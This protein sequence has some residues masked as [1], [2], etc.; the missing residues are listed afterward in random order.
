MIP[1]RTDRRLRHTPWV[2]LTLIAVNAFVFLATRGQIDALHQ[3]PGGVPFSAIADQFPVL[4]YYLNPVSP[5]WT[6]Y[7]TYQFLHAGWEHLIFNM[8]F[9]YVFGNSLE[10]RLGPLGY[11]F[12]YLAGGVVAGIGHSL[13][14]TSPVLGASGSVSAVTGGFLALF[15]LSHVTVL[16][17]IILIFIFECP[18]IYFIALA[19]AKDV[20]FQFVG[21]EGVAYLAHISG[22][23]YGFGVGMALL[24]SR[25]LPREH[26]DFL[27]LVDR[28]NRRRQFRAMTAGGV[29]P[30]QADAAATLG[31]RKLSDEEEQLMRLRA[32]AQQ[33]LRERNEDRALAAYEQLLGLDPQQV[34]PRQAQLGLA[35]LATH[36]GRYDLAAAAY[37]GFLRAHPR[38]PDNQEF[39]LMLGLIYGR[40]LDQP[41][42]ARQLLIEARA[43]HENPARRALAETLL[44]E[45]GE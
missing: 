15:P 26:Y 8:L 37:E 7:L 3:A 23:I 21:S 16:W 11:L 2:N 40:H 19:F 45:I 6:Q 38:D 29:S 17:P 31:E 13:T 14:S 27:A 9:L 30:W 12:F 4:G 24:A 1:L 33:H 25:I 34:L 20:L 18:S 42:R 28:W 41:E 39:R 43:H 35:S 5:N 36:A 44:A 22:N 10:D 32:A